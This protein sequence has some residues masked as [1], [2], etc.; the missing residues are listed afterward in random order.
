MILL[1]DE[2]PPSRGPLQL[3]TAQVEGDEKDERERGKREEA[4][5]TV[6]QLNL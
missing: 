5:H 4:A 1:H 6:V 3:Q 2:R